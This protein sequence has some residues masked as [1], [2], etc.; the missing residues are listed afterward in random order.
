MLTHASCDASVRCV[1]IQRLPGV[2]GNLTDHVALHVV[3]KR[4]SSVVPNR[5][6]CELAALAPSA[7]PQAGR[8]DSCNADTPAARY[9]ATTPP[10]LPRADI[11][12]VAI[13]N[14]ATRALRE[15]WAS[16]EKCMEDPARKEG[17]PSD[18]NGAGLVEW[19]RHSNTR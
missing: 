19:G 12:V 10:P 4:V 14:A 2:W 6:D 7:P 5:A 18:P 1:A 15:L 17:E 11:P 8:S 3:L 13:A 16:C 9:D